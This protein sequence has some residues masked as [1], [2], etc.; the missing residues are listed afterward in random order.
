MN[1]IDRCIKSLEVQVNDNAKGGIQN[2]NTNQTQIT[3]S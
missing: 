1:N 2:E 3:F